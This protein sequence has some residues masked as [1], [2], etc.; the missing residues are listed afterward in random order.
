MI[1]QVGRVSPGWAGA[2]KGR[3]LTPFMKIGLNVQEQPPAKISFRWKFSTQHYKMRHL[4]SLG[5]G[6]VKLRLSQNN[7]LW[8]HLIGWSFAVVLWLIVKRFFC[9]TVVSVPR[10]GETISVTL[11]FCTS[12]SSATQLFSGHGGRL[13]IIVTVCARP[14]YQVTAR[15]DSS[16]WLFS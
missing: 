15:T 5:L 1:S 16:P 11:A 3:L 10:G 4:R 9:T 13:D 7:K 14:C 2:I 6:M 8:V 12:P